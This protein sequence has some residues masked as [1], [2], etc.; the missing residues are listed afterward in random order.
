MFAGKE[1][2]RE[3]RAKLR[4]QKRTETEQDL[5]VALMDSLFFSTALVPTIRLLLMLLLLLLLLLPLILF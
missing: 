2:A 1:I 5:E 3:R 4:E